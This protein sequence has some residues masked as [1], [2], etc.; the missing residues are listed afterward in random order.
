VPPQRFFVAAVWR[1]YAR[2]HGAIV[3]DLAAWRRLTGDRRV[4][5]AALWLA[6]GAAIE[7][8]AKQVR[9]SGPNPGEL[10]VRSVGS[11][12]E[13]SLRIFDRSFAVTWALEAVAI[14]VAL[15]GVASAWSAEAIARRR[16][17]GMLRHLGATAGAIMRQFAIEAATLVAAALAWGLALG[18]AIALVLVH[19]VNPQ[20]FHWTMDVTWPVS[21][22]AGGALALIALAVAVAV[23]AARQAGSVAPVQAV[24]EDW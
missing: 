23:L 24:K 6:P 11:L 1:D 13:I 22:L 5:D 3:I 20:S 10:I 4:T 7:T 19:R 15:F 8:V 16:E 18:A 12:R 14:L 17:F 9:E 2:Q 21:A